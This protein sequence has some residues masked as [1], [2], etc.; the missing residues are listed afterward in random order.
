VVL[1]SF[2]LTVTN[3]GAVSTLQIEIKLTFLCVD[4]TEGAGRIVTGVVL[5][6]SATQSAGVVVVDVNAT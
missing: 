6:V 3:A 1:L 2:N 4:A 5:F